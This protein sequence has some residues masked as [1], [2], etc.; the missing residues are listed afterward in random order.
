LT[1][2]SEAGA[3]AASWTARSVEAIQFLDFKRIQFTAII[4]AQAV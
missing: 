4:A 1:I 2:L 3:E